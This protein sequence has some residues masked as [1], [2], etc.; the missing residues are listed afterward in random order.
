MKLPRRQFLHLAAGAAAMSAA[1]RVASAQNYY[2]TRPV[3]VIVAYAPG[4]QTD[5]IARLLAQK[6]S[7]H[8]GMQYYVENVPGAGGNIGMG[9]AAQAAADGY[10]LMMIDVTSYVVNPSLYNKV[11]YDPFKDFDPIALAVTTTQVLMVHPSL[12]VQ[13]VKDLIAL[14][15]ANPGKYSYASA[16]VGSPSHL[17]SELFRISLGLDFVHVPFN[18]AGPA[19]ASTLGGHTPIAFGSPA[20]S[21]AQLKQGNLRALAVAT[22]TRLAALPDVPTMAESGL[23]DI[24]C[25][26]RLGV[27]APAGTPNDIIALLNREIGKMVALPDVKERLAA[28]GFEPLANTP[29]ES[30]AVI[31]ADGTK[32]AKVIRDAGI[33]AE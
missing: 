16:G 14:I 26:A 2:P 17:T 24:E 30:A 31:R 12:S 6:L 27:V 20:S 11:P 33:K 8:F 13:T 29:D 23:P 5:A 15:K 21:V 25:D 3:R 9:R 18:G 19:I 4:G 10:T 28:L 22:K 1:S 7:D 32:W